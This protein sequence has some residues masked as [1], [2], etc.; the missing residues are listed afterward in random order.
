M[1]FKEE[2]EVET[3]TPAMG[4]AEDIQT[5]SEVSQGGGDADYGQGGE[6]DYSR[7]GAADYTGQ[8]ESRGGGAGEEAMMDY[9]AE[10]SGSFAQ[11]Q[12]SSDGNQPW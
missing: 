12:A 9:D 3:T 6:A 11:P 1:L 5:M 8:D 4:T 10:G 7:V 2:E